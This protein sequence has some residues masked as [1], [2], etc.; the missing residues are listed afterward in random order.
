MILSTLIFPEIQ[1]LSIF[2]LN[3]IHLPQFTYIWPT[4][5]FI[6]L[7]Y[8]PDLIICAIFTPDRYSY[9]VMYV[10]SDALPLY[11]ILN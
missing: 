1:F 3:Y 5:A 11:Q 7:L 2:S 8:C 4:V 10:S 6:T 9:I